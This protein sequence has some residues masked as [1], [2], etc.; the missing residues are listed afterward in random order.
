MS[1]FY[2]L[3]DVARIRVLLLQLG[4]ALRNESVKGDSCSGTVH[5]SQNRC[6]RTD[7]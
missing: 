4:T 1:V 6:L 7:V 3:I 5:L 2:H